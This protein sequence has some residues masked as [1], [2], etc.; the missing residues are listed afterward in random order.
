VGGSARRRV[1]SRRNPDPALVEQVQ[2]ALRGANRVL[3]A[4]LRSSLLREGL[5]FSRFLVLRLL[6]VR[7]PTTSKALAEAMGVTTA[8]MPGLIDGLEAEGLVRRKRSTKDRREILVSATAKGRRMLARLKETAVAELQG[9]FEGWTEEEL[10]ALLA[11]LHRIAGRLPSEELI[12][13]KVL[14]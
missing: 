3:F 7:G 5:P 12:Q 1:T 2:R 11:S 4:R 9:A 8:N 6:A 13:L 10:R 14:P